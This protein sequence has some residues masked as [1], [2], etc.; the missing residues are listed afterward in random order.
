MSRRGSVQC[1]ICRHEARGAIERDLVTGILHREIGRRHGVSIFALRRHLKAHVT[2][3]RKAS[4]LAGPV[5]L[6]KLVDEAAE[7][8]VSLLDY[9]RATRITLARQ[10]MK[11]DE[12]NERTVLPMLAKALT[13]TARLESQITGE[14]TKHVA[15]LVTTQ[16]TVNFYGSPDWVRLRDELLALGRAHG[17]K[18]MTAV[19]QMLE[20]LDEEPSRRGRTQQPAIEHQPE[21]E[22]DAE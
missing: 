16:N 17:H 21:T 19:I 5:A 20:R 18:V 11:A 12:A 2:Q 14:I 6:S 4:L 9:L 10:L 8:G 3:E 1:Q 7:A 13:E 15:P 22:T